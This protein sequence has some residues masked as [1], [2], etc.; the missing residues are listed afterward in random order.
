MAGAGA[1]MSWHR[2]RTAETQ[3]DNRV[4]SGDETGHGTAPTQRIELITRRVRA[5]LPLV[6]RE[7]AGSRSGKPRAW[8]LDR[9]RSSADT[10]P[11]RA[12]VFLAPPAGAAARPPASRRSD[13][14]SVSDAASAHCGSSMVTTAQRFAGLAC[15]AISS[16]TALAKS[17]IAGGVRTRVAALYAIA[18]EIGSSPAEHRQRVRQE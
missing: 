4:R 5:S 10:A 15:D 11:S 3:Q 1:R 6:N 7:E 17:P 13:E 9:P 18:A 12:T 14:C 2:E 16:S 8:E